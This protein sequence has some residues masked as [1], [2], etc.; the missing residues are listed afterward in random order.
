MKIAIKILL[1]TVLISATLHAQLRSKNLREEEETGKGT[2]NKSGPI[3]GAN[4]EGRPPKAIT[5]PIPI[6]N[7]KL[8][9]ITGANGDGRPPITGANGEGRPPKPIS[10][11]KNYLR[12]EEKTE[13]QLS[14]E[15][16]GNHIWKGNTCVKCADN[17]KVSTDKRSCVPK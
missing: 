3:T 14:C 9:P 5:G 1:L 4:G 12:E 13:N 16:K 7:Q 17:Q 6:P 8:G 15:K 2:K 11:P 10:G